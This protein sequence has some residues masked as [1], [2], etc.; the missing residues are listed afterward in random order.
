MSDDKLGLRE[1]I[2]A[3]YD[4]GPDFPHRL[5]LSRIS[6]ELDR[7]PEPKGQRRL[8]AGLA[9]AALT[10]L[11]VVAGIVVPRFWHV[12]A[13]IPLTPPPV[14]H[15]GVVAMLANN[16]LAYVPSGASKAL[17]DMEIASAP[18]L[19]ASHGYSS[20]GHRVAMSPDGSLIY[21]LPAQD[22]LGGTQLVIA[23]PATGQVVQRI[24]LPNSSGSARYG[25]LTVAPFGDIWIVGSIGTVLSNSGPSVRQIEIV[26]VRAADHSVSSWL[27]RVMSN[28]VP[29]GPVSG[30]FEVYEVQVGTDERRVYYSYTGG[31][32]GQTGLDWVDLNGQQATTCAPPAPDSACVP[33]LA[34]FLVEGTEVFITTPNDQPSGAID[35]FTLNGTM[36][37][38]IALGLLPGFLEGFAVAPDGMHIVVFGSCGYS[39]GMAVIDLTT[40]TSKVIVQA[41]SAHSPPTNLP[42]GQSS[43]FVSNNLI[44]LGHVGALLP[45]NAAGQILYVDSASGKVVQSVAVSAEPIALVALP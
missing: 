20:L 25:A 35:H 2:Q 43:L 31:L 16:H 30:D 38:H 22:F 6:A 10:L 11:I 45:S 40:Q 27:G 5:L 26:R 17:W 7:R 42:C 19:T 24:Q 14:A 32:L 12:P 18:D 21:A 44:A 36:S 28:W 13:P 9:T 33:G 41:E 4:F 29:Q 1:A 37:K 15:A 3:A 39:G 8:V 34:G 23:A